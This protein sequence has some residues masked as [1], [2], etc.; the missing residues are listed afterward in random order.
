MTFQTIILEECKEFLTRC[1]FFR[2]GVVLADAC[3][4]CFYCESFDLFFDV[5]V[6]V[7]IRYCVVISDLRSVDGLFVQM[8][9]NMCKYFLHKNEVN[10]G[11]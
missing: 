1:G 3:F 8:S 9:L 5:L 10:L 7:F 6:H 2:G 11:F 4:C